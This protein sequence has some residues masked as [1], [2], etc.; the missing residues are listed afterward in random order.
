M[1]GGCGQWPAFWSYSPDDWPNG[2][3]VDMIEVYFILYIW[4]TD[5]YTDYLETRS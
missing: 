4:N 3:E 1:P 2:S 5:M